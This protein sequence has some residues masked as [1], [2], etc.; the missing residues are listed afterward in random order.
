MDDLTALP[1]LGPAPGA[2]AR[3]WAAVGARFDGNTTDDAMLWMTAAAGFGH[4]VPAALAELVELTVDGD[5]GWVVFPPAGF[6]L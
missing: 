1:A 4:L 3:C 2:G 6:R 5:V